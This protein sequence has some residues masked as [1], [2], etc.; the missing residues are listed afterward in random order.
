MIIENSFD[1]DA[2][3]DRV[4]EFLQN[5]HN[6]AT[7]F[8]GAELTEDLGDDRYKGK[9]KIK[10]GPVTAS[11]SGTARITEKDETARVAVL[12]AEGKDARGSGTAKATATM[13]VEPKEDGGS[14]V[15]LKTDL[16]ISGR[17]AQF[18]RG[19]MA[20]VSNRMVG[21]L[22]ARVRDRIEAEQESGTADAPATETPKPPATEAPAA[23]PATEAPAT[24]TAATDAAPSEAGTSAGTTEAEA[25]VPTAPPATTKAATDAGSGTADDTA[26]TDDAAVPAETAAAD[27]A[28]SEAPV[29]TAPPTADSDSATLSGADTT[30]TE[31]P[32]TGSGTAA[33]AAPS[34]AG[35]SAGTTETEAP[36]PTAP[37]A[38]EK[39]KSAAP[40]EATGKVPASSSASSAEPASA[41]KASTMIKVVVA[42][43]FRRL[44]ARLRGRSD[45]D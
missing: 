23:S 20:D 45:R 33:D 24:E 38:A 7:C 29:P 44:F 35:T 4:F 13:R 5:P 25:P 32:D 31:A 16:T 19:I 36:V 37:P 17:L 28:P 12:V 15:L 21:D 39:G 41:I 42:G 26:K 27:A 40:A 43:M 14:S 11:F 18:G 9:V 1:V 8:P 10:L 30:E 22:A 2:D 34:E 6:V 3:P